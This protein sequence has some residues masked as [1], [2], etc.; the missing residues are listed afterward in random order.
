MRQ[1]HGPLENASP[2]PIAATI[3]LELIGHTPGTL[4]SLAAGILARDSFDLAR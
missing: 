1:S 2:A 3:A 4:T